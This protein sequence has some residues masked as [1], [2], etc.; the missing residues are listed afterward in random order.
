MHTYEGII[1]D[2]RVEIIGS[3]IEDAK[4]ALEEH[5]L[6]VSSDGMFKIKDF[7]LKKLDA[8]SDEGL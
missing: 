2:L 5:M 8:W 6:K 1:T 4:Q 3:D 7:Y